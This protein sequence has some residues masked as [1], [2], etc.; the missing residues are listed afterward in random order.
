[1]Q[2]HALLEADEKNLL[3]DM[4]QTLRA[5]GHQATMQNAGQLIAK[6][7]VSGQHAI[8]DIWQKYLTSTRVKR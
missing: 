2:Q 7:N 6:E 5:L 3:S 8:I 1:M 4:Y